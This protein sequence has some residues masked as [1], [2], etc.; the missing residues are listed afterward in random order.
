MAMITKSFIFDEPFPTPECH[1]STIVVLEN[2]DAVAAWFGGTTESAA[3]VL[4]WYSRYENGVW[5]TPA[6]IP[7]EEAVPH[8]NPVLFQTGENTI[9]LYY[10]VGFQIP[11]WKTMFVTST[12][13]GRNWSVPQELVPGDTSGGRGPVK[14]KPIRLTDGTLLAPASTEQGNWQCF[15]DAFDGHTWCK[16]PIPMR[17]SDEDSVGLIQPTLWESAKDHVHALM[18]STAG[19]IYRSDSH[20]NGKNWCAAYPTQMPNN[21]SGLDCAMTRGGLVLVC[22]PVGENWGARSPLSVFL[23]KDNGDTFQK[24]AD[25]ETQ[26]G[27]YSYPAIVAH[28]NDVYITYT[29]QRKK[30]VF[31]RLQIDS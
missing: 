3:D 30:I 15:I 19:R 4:I 20:D 2:G 17:S 11:H 23:S 5:S 9:T 16:Y 24:I 14:N 27:E 12:D 18:R 21:N 28:G 26:P 29:Y 13:G 25:L 1:A 6:S 7:S 22:N 31:C 8:W 10:K